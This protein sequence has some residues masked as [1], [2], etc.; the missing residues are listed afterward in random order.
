MKH[1]IKKTVLL[2]AISTAL[3]TSAFA[4]TSYKANNFDIRL[5]GTSNIHDWQ[6]KAT[7]GSSD[8]TFVIDGAGH[9]TAITR[10][11]FTLPAKNL[12]SE[13]TQMDN[14]TYKALKTDKNPNITFV[15]T[16]ATIKETSANTYQINCAGTLTIA[17][18]AKKIDLVA[19]GKFNP[20]DKSLTVTGVEKMKMTDFSVDP[21]K[22]L[23]GTIKTGDAISISYNVK[24]TK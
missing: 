12:K 11:S 17:G 1:L 19:T 15:G 2:M 5:N 13:H 24:F 3:V 22:A 10:L 16:S 23:L 14:N 18:T 4:Q 9:V 7:A 21:P 20:A 6:M 8:A